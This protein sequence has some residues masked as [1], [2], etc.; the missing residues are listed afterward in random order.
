MYRPSRDSSCLVE[1]IQN[2]YKLV[3]HSEAS[4]TSEKYLEPPATPGGL[5]KSYKNYYKLVR[6][7]E[8]STTSEK[9]LGPPGT[10]GDL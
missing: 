1:V 3:R 7:S 4:T 9:Y 5:Y 8:A 6:H 2:I 10:P